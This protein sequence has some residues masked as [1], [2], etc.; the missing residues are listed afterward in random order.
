MDVDWHEFDLEGLARQLRD[1]RD[2]RDAERTLW[3]FERVL[4]I[5]RGD[6]ELLH[7]VLTAAVCM[8]ARAD[9]TTPRHVLD[10]YFRR[11]PRTSA[12]TRTFGRWWAR[13]WSPEGLPQ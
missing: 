11:A 6:P 3:A 10:T 8:V 5:A 4:E 13:C 9:A 7:Y 1:D 12:G 2:G